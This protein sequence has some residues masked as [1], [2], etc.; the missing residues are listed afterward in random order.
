[1]RSWAATDPARSRPRTELP[2]WL[3]EPWN[4]LVE[5]IPVDLEVTARSYKALQRRRDIRSAADLLR[6]VLI[7]AL[8]LSLRV[9]ATW[10]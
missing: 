8:T 5:T 6:L 3:N 7:Y 1:V 9:T 10:F 2:I 4:E